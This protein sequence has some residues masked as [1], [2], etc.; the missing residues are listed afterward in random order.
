MSHSLPPHHITQL[1]ITKRVREPGYSTMNHCVLLL[2]GLD[3]LNQREE[4]AFAIFKPGSFVWPYRRDTIDGLQGGQIV[5]FKDDPTGF[6]IGDCGLDILNQP[7]SLSV[8]SV[9]LALRGEYRESGVSATA[10]PKTSW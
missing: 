10:V 3:E 6:E 7:E 2:S 8:G 5:L 4:I 1:P 9:G